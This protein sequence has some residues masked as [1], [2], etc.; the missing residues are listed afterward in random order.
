MHNTSTLL[1]ILIRT[2]DSIPLDVYTKFSPLPFWE[3]VLKIIM[4]YPTIIMN[5]ISDIGYQ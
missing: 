3:H 5:L 4:I 2:D 1:V